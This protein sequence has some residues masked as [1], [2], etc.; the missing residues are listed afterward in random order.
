VS[1]PKPYK[2]YPGPNMAL[3]VTALEEMARHLAPS[4]IFELHINPAQVIWTRTLL[5]KLSCDVEE[6]PF[7]P[8]VNL[9]LEKTL[10]L[11][12]WYVVDANGKA[13]G[14]EGL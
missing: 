11:L 8:Y 14:C 13:I 9:V 12:E 2:I 3:C 7:A 4:S 1:E 6:N 5:R 10:G